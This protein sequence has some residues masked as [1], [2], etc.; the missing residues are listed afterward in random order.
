MKQLNNRTNSI[1]TPVV[2]IKKGISNKQE[3]IKQNG[4]FLIAN[5][6]NLLFIFL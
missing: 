2:L 3:Q 1:D 5:K 4:N 6:V